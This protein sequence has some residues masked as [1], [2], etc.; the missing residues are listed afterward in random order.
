[1]SAKRKPFGMGGAIS[2]EEDVYIERDVDEEALRLLRQGRHV[3]LHAGRQVG[4]TS[5]MFKLRSALM[6][7][8]HLCL[9]AELFMLFTSNT[10]AD[11]MEALVEHLLKQCPEAPQA[12]AAASMKPEQRLK[13]LLN[14]LAARAPAGRRVYL[15]LDELDI[16]LRFRAEALAGLF[17]TLRTFCQ[18]REH[19]LTVLLLSVLTPTEMIMEHETGGIGINVFADLPVRL[20]ENTSEVREQL[21]AQGFPDLEPGLIDPILKR[22]LDLTGGQPYLT[23]LI[24]ERLQAAD[25]PPKCL[26]ELEE[27]LLSTFDSLAEGHLM[28]IRKQFLDTGRRLFSLAQTYREVLD[29]QRPTN[30]H[31]LVHLRNIGIIRT[32][33][34]SYRLSN[35]IYEKLLDWNW[36]EGLMQSQEPRV[37]RERASRRQLFSRRVAVLLCGGTI[38]MIQSDDGKAHFQGADQR[39]E[40]FVRTELD[41]IASVI[42]DWFDPRDGINMT[43]DRWLDIARYIHGNR[44]RFD[45]FVVAHGTDTLAFTASAVAFMLGNSFP[46]PVVFTGAQTTIDVPYGDTRDNLIR[47]CYVAACDQRINEVQILFGDRVLRAVRAV[48]TDDRTFDGFDSPGL[49]P[50]ARIAEELIVNPVAQRLPKR[51][52]PFQPHLAREI[53][54]ITLVPGLRVDRFRAALAVD[55]WVGIDGVVISTPGLGNIPSI[56][57]YNFRPF[58]EEAVAARVPV[59]ITSQMPINP[60]TRE[61]YEMASVPAALGAIPAGNLTIA[62]AYTKFAW[63]IGCT[64]HEY[65][66]QTLDRESY[67]AEIKR[68]MWTDYIGESM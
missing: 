60:Y 41:G 53:L 42:A 17:A 40:Q 68:K 11:G 19:S 21:R 14:L 43:P 47:A 62:A 34:A 22:V 18:D 10:L 4:K 58:I 48:K 28:G 67:L 33:G 29:G 6:A 56:P 32:E 45:A 20:F 24:C 64:Q 1:M 25:D 31:N 38:G 55:G 23:C 2:T 51:S 16:L 36:L 61:Q 35:P 26:A 54:Y 8:G 30:Q 27:K 13:E 63:V 57:P 7:E 15:M 46:H 37:T 50:L 66:D 49:E 5:L 65:R 44:D 3:N 59:L 12:T 9:D 52:D 39:L